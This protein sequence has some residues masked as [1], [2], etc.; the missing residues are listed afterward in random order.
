MDDIVASAVSA[1][2][3]MVGL[4]LGQTNLLIVGVGLICLGAA[5]H[6][7]NEKARWF[8]PIGWVCIGVYFYLGAEHYFDISDPVLIF[9]S[10][11]ALPV[12]RAYGVWD[13]I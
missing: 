4:D 6:S 9:M 8:A 7:S 11:A 1:F 13:A 5:F 2:G 3:R 10:I 12:C